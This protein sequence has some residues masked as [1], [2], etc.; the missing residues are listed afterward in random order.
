MSWR[1][2]EGMSTAVDLKACFILESLQHRVVGCEVDYASLGGVHRF[3]LR[4]EDTKVEVGVHEQV[5]DGFRVEDLKQF[6]SW[7]V[8]H[9]SC[10]RA[11]RSILIACR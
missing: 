6:L 3:R 7:L 4:R 5:L 10:E 9:L 2:C 1:V 8:G 11:P